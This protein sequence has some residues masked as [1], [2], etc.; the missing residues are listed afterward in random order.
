MHL[1]YNIRRDK[2]GKPWPTSCFSVVNQNRKSKKGPP[3]QP[4]TGKYLPK[5]PKRMHACMYVCSSA[6]L[7]VGPLAIL[8]HR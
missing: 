1:F 3:H 8:L 2:A 5:V 4:H 7:H 6:A